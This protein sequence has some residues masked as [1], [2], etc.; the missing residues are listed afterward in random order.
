MKVFT[1]FICLI[2][3]WEHCFYCMKVTQPSQLLL[4]FHTIHER[5]AKKELKRR[6]ERFHRIVSLG[7]RKALI[8]QKTLRIKTIILMKM[9]SKVY[10]FNL[11]K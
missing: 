6:Q 3:Q 5:V 9:V 4:C 1:T 2:F 10:I 7:S 11:V 8:A